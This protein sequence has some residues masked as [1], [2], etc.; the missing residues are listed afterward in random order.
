MYIRPICRQHFEISYTT[1]VGFQPSGLRTIQ[2]YQSNI[3]SQKQ[4]TT[5]TT[6]CSG[7]YIY[8]LPLKKTVEAESRCSTIFLMIHQVTGL[9]TQPSPSLAILNLDIEGIPPSLRKFTTHLFPAAKLVIL[10]LWRATDPPEVKEVIRT[11]SIH[12]TYESMLANI[13]GKY[14]D[15]HLQ[16]QPWIE[17]YKA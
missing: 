17:W 9:H 16:W 11:F 7:E 2:L 10:R 3:L 14:A 8:I 12:H 1:T 6:N 4:K 13:E 5:H 15:F